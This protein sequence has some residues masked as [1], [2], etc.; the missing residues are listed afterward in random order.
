MSQ[1]EKHAEGFFHR[2]DGSAILTL[3]GIILLFST[4]IAMTL[5]A[6]RHVDDTWTTPSSY[7]Q[8]QMYEI[9]D[10]ALYI[11]SATL[12]TPHLLFVHRLTKGTSLLAFRESEI[13]RIVAPPE[14]EPYITRFGE[15]PLKLTSNLLL[16]RKPTPS[17]SEKGFDAM[18]A[19]KT[20]REKLGDSQEGKNI[21]YQILELYAPQQDEVFSLAETDGIVEFFV[22]RDFVILEKD[23]P[24]AFHKD[25]GVIYVKNPQMFRYKKI[26]ETEAF[27]W[28][29]DPEG[30]EV[31]NLDELKSLPFGFKSR[32]ELIELGE[33][34]FA[35]EGC[36]YCHTDQTR[37]LVQDVVLNGSESFPAPPSSPHEYIYQKV[38]FPGTKRNGPDISRVGI[39]RPSRDWHK[40]HFWSPKTASVGSIMPAFQHF[41]DDDPRGSSRS[42]VGVPNYKFEAIFQYLMTKGTRITP[43]TQAWWLG[44]DPV[45]TLEIIES[46]SNPH[47]E[48]G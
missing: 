25:P 2:L 45:R 33:H 20:L 12:S 32:K 44:K 13:V 14:L 22:D 1:S 26:G 17:S 21:H 36:W 7:Y 4:A 47:G 27:A 37:T 34:I 10:P 29:Y 5:I 23:T 18:A 24:S 46:R 43:P 35:Y 9:A 16:L 15:T 6:P 8:V 48:E 38:T 40:A 28:D 3:V 31:K 39:K 30:V 11:S 41:F 19:V 42:V